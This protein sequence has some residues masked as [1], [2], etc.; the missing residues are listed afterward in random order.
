MI[1]GLVVEFVVANPLRSWLHD[2]SSIE[3]IKHL[4]D[5]LDGFLF[6][7]ALNNYKCKVVLELVYNGQNHLF[8]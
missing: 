2:I 7:N 4:D 3:E 8:W 6:E 1:D 5:L